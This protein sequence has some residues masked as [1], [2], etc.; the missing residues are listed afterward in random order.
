MMLKEI[1]DRK[2]GE[3]KIV[4]TSD[5]PNE[6]YCKICKL[7]RA[8]RSRNLSSARKRRRMGIKPRNRR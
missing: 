7:K 1:L 4:F 5:Y 2:C 3:C 8:K 6:K